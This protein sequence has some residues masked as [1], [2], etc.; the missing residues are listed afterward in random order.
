MV[1][2]AGGNAQNRSRSPA[3][4]HPEAK[5][6]KSLQASID[7]AQDNADRS[8]LCH[9]KSYMI[10]RYWPI[11]FLTSYRRSLVWRDIAEAKGALHPSAPGNIAHVRQ[12]RRINLPRQICHITGI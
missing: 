10:G 11:C 4:A 2:G 3:H 1:Q 9:N 7:L 8:I 5:E 12:Q 6:P